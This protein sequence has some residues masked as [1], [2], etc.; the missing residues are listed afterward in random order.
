M[1]VT[2]TAQ[3]DTVPDPDP[4]PVHEADGT[5][6]AGTAAVAVAAEDA[7]TIDAMTDGIPDATTDAAVDRPP[8]AATRLRLHPAATLRHAARAPAL[9]DARRLNPS[10]DHDQDPDPDLHRR[11]RVGET[12]P[13][14][15]RRTAPMSEMTL[16]NL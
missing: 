6:T 1:A 4:D 2:T 14:Q 16:K 9:E 8:S 10:P 15:Q 7:E 12:R 13:R 3:V 5:G 11:R